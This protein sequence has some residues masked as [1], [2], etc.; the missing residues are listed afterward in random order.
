MNIK[1][2]IRG[3]LKLASLLKYVAF[4]FV[5][6]LIA[7]STA[8]AG[9]IM[10]LHDSSGNLG[11]VD[12]DTGDISLI[13]NMGSVM[14]D[15]AFDTSGNLWGI[16]FTGLYSINASNA[17]TSFVGNHGISGGNALVFG[18]DGTLYAA[19]N[20]T[21][22]LFTVDTSTG[23]ASSLGNMGFNS[24]GDLAFA[25]GAFY[26]ASSGA[27]LIKVDLTDPS[28]SSVVGNFGV[29]NM[30]GLATG[31]DGNL[32]GV[33][34]TTVYSV[35]LLTGQ[36]TN[37]VSYAGQGMGQAFG[38]SFYTEA[39]AEVPEPGTLA[40]FGLGLLGLGITRRLRA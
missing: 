25:G 3:H 4:A 40:L 12:V 27:Q 21:S 36:A 23:S 1:Q 9:P 37:G 28:N 14:T 8:H 11:T 22:N 5:S 18:S 34:G 31:D 39:G 33:A 16:T 29:N 20:T 6:L 17:S 2:G 24:G 13:G 10:H 38:Q 7:V 19:G 35:D 32:Y 30:F 15:I 26:M